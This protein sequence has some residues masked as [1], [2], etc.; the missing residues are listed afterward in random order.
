[1]DVD[2]FLGDILQHEYD[3]VKAREYYLRTRKLKGRERKILQEDEIPATSK[4]GA[5]LVDFDGGNGGR[6]TYEDGTT[7]DGNGWNSDQK[8][9]GRSEPDTAERFANIDSGI[10][11]VRANVL[12]YIKDPAIQKAR[13]AQL[14]DFQR[15]SDAKKA[16]A[17][18]TRKPTAQESANART[19]VN[20]T[21]ASIDKLRAGAKNF[22][23][24]A[25]KN[26]YLDKVDD[27]Q[28]R[29]NKTK[30]RLKMKSAAKK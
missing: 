9:K 13:L 22:K 28:E 25:A 29:L 1:M 24:E 21:Q 16:K 26:A 30:V 8:A 20:K 27:L 12:K 5:K 4:T 6:A 23:N 3:P 2:E 7:F 15:R 10:K 18:V 11:K 14:D 17:I 19:A